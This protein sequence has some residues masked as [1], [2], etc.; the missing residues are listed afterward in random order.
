[1]AGLRPRLKCLK[2][3]LVAMAYPQVLETPHMDIV[4]GS[5]RQ[6]PRQVKVRQTE[7]VLGPTDDVDTPVVPQTPPS[8]VTRVEKGPGRHDVVDRLF[9]L[10][11]LFRGVRV[12]VVET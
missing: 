11:D 3:M 6:S 2:E 7:A 10:A 12:G 5:G 1:M 4:V 8:T 9:F